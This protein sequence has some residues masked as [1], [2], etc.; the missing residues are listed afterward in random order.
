MP[1]VGYL[2]FM[3]LQA[4]VRGHWA[5]LGLLFLAMIQGGDAWGQVREG[6]WTLATF[7]VRYDNPTDPLKWGDRVDEVAQVMGFY[8]IVGIQEALPNQVEDLRQRLPWMDVVSRGR[9]ADEGG[10]ACAIFY[11]K[12]KWQ[13][14]HHDTFWL[15]DDWTTPGAHGWTADLPRVVTVVKL[16]Q[17]ATGKLVT[18]FN[19][20]WSHVSQEAR[21]GSGRLIALMDA[22]STSDA[23]VVLGDFNETSEGQGRQILASAGFDDVYDTRRAR[24]RKEF[25]TYTTFSPEGSSGGP[26]IDAIYTKGLVTQWTCV[27]EVIKKD[28]F[29]SDHLPVHAVVS[30]AS[31]RE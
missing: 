22:L 5:S 1:Q 8:D 30:W 28:L 15:S 11:H 10:E 27:D 13:L 24:C 3:R 9:D 25:P 17:V 12:D 16:Q 7:N 14:L 19:T 2:R 31:G 26:R 18:A 29:I 6:E 4:N 21:E 20:H 23:S